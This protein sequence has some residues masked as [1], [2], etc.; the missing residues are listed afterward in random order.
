MILELVGNVAL[1]IF[2]FYIITKSADF[3][4]DE[5]A[6][7]GKSYN[8]SKLMI[9][10]TIVAVGTSL[11]EMITSLGSILFTTNYSDFI[12]G[13]T[14]GSNLTNILLAFGIFLIV[15]KKFK[16]E[17][18]EMFNVLAL[19][20]TSIVFVAFI[21]LGFVNYFAIS[22]VIFYV[23]YIFYLSKFQKEEVT[24]LEEEYVENEK[25]PMSKSVGIIILSFVGLYIGAKIVIYSVENI[26]V[27][28][29]IPTAYLTL[30]TISVATSLPEIAVTISSARKKEYLMGIGNIL[31]TNI[32]NISLII[33][34][35]GFF[36]YYTINTAQYIFPIILFLIGTL[37]FSYLI[38]RR[39]FHRYY[40]YFFLFLYVVYILSFLKEIVM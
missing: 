17:K 29:D 14:L 10:L 38:I 11:P 18:R 25:H 35:S 20:F 1:F 37:I 26:G 23:F 13:T 22:L 8:M 19:V 33:G 12:I 7:I 2:S 24:K 30:T 16:T 40:G 39:R 5:A 28:L 3:F 27:L 31:G 34:L 36:G 15:S 32:L 4:I 21:L 9:G 6:M